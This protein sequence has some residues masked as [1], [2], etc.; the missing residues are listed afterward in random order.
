M[1][2]NN[3][4]SEKKDDIEAYLKIKTVTTPSVIPYIEIS[5]SG[6]KISL[7]K[8]EN[9]NDNDKT[10]YTYDVDKVFKENDEYSYIYEEVTLDCISESLQGRNFCFISF[11]ESSSEK[12]SLIFGGSNCSKNINERGIFPRLIETFLSKEISISYSLMCVNGKR[13]I[14]LTKYFN[15]ELLSLSIDDFT[16]SSLEIQQSPEIIYEMTKIPIKHTNEITTL[17]SHFNKIYQHLYF[18]EPSSDI[19][20]NS[21]SHFIYALY[22]YDSED[23][24]LS[25]IT[26][27]ELSGNDM[28]I[29]KVTYPHSL[30]KQ[31][32]LNTKAII[33]NTNT[34]ECIKRSIKSLKCSKKKNDKHQEPSIENA[35]VL[36]VLQKLSFTSYNTKFIILGCIYP[37]V[38]MQETVRD[39]LSFLFECKKISKDKVIT[40]EISLTNKED[41]NSN[42]L[43]Y[44]Y[45]AKERK[46]QIMIKE[47]TEIIKY[48]NQRIECIQELYQKQIQKLKSA[49]NFEGDVNMLLGGNDSTR[50]A[51]FAKKIREALIDSSNKQSQNEEL[52][53]KKRELEQKV[54]KL[55][56]KNEVI[57]NDQTMLEYVTQIREDKLNEQEKLK[58]HLEKSKELISLKESNAKLINLNKEYMKEIESKNAII[59]NFSYILNDKKEKSKTI[60]EI[61]DNLKIE[62]EE[63]S[64]AEYNSLYSQYTREV[65]Q[66]KEKYEGMIRQKDV[67]ISNMKNSSNQLVIKQEIS[68]MKNEMILLYDSLMN[69]INTFK[70]DFNFKMPSMISVTKYNQFIT[71]KDNYA[72]LI[73]DT[74]VK[75]NLTN[76]PITLKEIESKKKINKRREKSSNAFKERNHSNNLQLLNDDEDSLL[77]LKQENQKLKKRIRE[78]I[79]LYDKKISKCVCGDK[80]HLANS[81]EKVIRK[82]EEMINE[83]TK[84]HIIMGAHQRIINRLN[85]ENMSMRSFMGKKIIKDKINFPLPSTFKK[86]NY[87]YSSSLNKSRSTNDMSSQSFI[88]PKTGILSLNSSKQCLS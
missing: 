43:I 31:G 52:M 87:I 54:D 2:D 53:N 32:L 9:K 45:E 82:L 1:K 76:Y 75:V 70:A 16:K 38:G 20:L 86:I 74:C 33:D 36:I 37:N 39:T 15:R 83:N 64:K 62:H 28:R 26:F 68:N 48:K 17:L 84:S 13:L 71:A 55:K 50:E 34:Y 80:E 11:G 63:K 3:I 14:D 79:D 57:Q 59:K 40:N 60:D 19:K 12:H 72:K 25:T 56:Q 42:D 22:V 30:N 44:K 77:E 27:C 73:D 35:K 41:E 61:K 69:L 47:Q 24:L 10:L 78:L 66:V 4:D 88:R 21:F 49:F 81:N 23:N 6:K 67:C 18:I 7:K 5:E 85:M 29:T 46:L 65:K 8:K 51:K 58:L